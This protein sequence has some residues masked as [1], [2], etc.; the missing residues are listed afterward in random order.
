MDSVDHA[1]TWIFGISLVLVLLAYYVG[2]V[3]DTNALFG[4]FNNLLKTVTG[5]NAAGNFAPYPA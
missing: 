5:R 2:T 4:N 1:L 3:A